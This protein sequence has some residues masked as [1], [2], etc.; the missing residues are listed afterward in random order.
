MKRWLSTLGDGNDDAGD[1]DYYAPD[2]NPIGIYI[3]LPI[4]ILALFIFVVIIRKFEYMCW[5]NIV[6]GGAKGAGSESTINPLQPPRA[7]VSDQP[8][9][10]VIP[11]RSE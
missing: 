5:N 6:L 10:L 4:I 2:S 7:A 11:H 8:G 3:G 9:S 1:D